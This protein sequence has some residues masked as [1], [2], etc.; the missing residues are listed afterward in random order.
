M[1]VFVVVFFSSRRRHTRCALVTGV[2][3]CAL[4]IYAVAVTVYDRTG[5]LA[6]TDEGQVLV[7]G[8]DAPPP[9][10][11]GVEGYHFQFQQA[12]DPTRLDTHRDRKSVVSGQSVSVRVVLGG[13]RIITKKTERNTQKQSRTT[14]K[15]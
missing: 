4:P 2:Q 12:A 1:Y 7:L 6:L 10:E 13:R 9:V 15:Y 14:T 8:D 3:T 5:T 11:V